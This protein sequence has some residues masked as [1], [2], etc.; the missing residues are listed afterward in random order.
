MR[1]EPLARGLATVRNLDCEIEEVK[2]AQNLHL[3][4]STNTQQEDL[5]VEIEKESKEMSG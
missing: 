1:N 4:V 3:I 5:R 2:H